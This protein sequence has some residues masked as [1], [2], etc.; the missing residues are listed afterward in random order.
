MLNLVDIQDEIFA[1][2]EDALAI[3]V[4][5]QA[6]PDANTVR[7]VDGKVQPYLAIQFGDLQD[8]AS[9]RGFTGVRSN[10]YELPIYVQVVAADPRTAR[11]IASGPVLDT[12]LGLSLDWTGEVRKRPGGGMFPVVNSN[13]ATEAYLFP[14]SLA[15]TV[16]LSESA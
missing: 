14:A 7:K 6:I 15:V 3:P 16:Q 13:G 4:F 12:L 10:D 11:R 1:E 8:R 9:G 5:E 2:L